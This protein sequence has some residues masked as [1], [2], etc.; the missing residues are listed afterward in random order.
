MPQRP[1]GVPSLPARPGGIVCW[2]G[3]A[4]PRGASVIEHPNRDKPGSRSTKAIV[5]GLLLASAVLMAIVTVGGWTRIHGAKPLQIAYI[6]RY[7]VIAFYIPR[8]RSGLLPLA[9]ALALVLLMFAAI[10][11]PGRFDGGKERFAR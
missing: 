3:M 10:S 6:L 9:A 2:P 4:Q 5:V 8:W 1:Q 11:A 7:L